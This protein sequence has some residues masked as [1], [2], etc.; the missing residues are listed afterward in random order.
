MFIQ[1]Y[2]K[3]LMCDKVYYEP[4][5]IGCTTPSLSC[6]DCRKYFRRIKGLEN[7]AP[8]T[9]DYKFIRLLLDRD[10]CEYCGRK[11]SW[12]EREIEHKTP[13]S[14]G[15]NNCNSNLC[16]SCHQCNVEKSDRTYEEYLDYRKT[17]DITSSEI[18]SKLDELSKHGLFKIEE[19]IVDEI[20]QRGFE[21]TNIKHKVIRDENGKVAGLRKVFIKPCYKVKIKW[22]VTTKRLTEW[23]IAYNE[24]CKKY[25]KRVL[26]ESIHSK[27]IEI[28]KDA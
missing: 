16:I 23:G 21:E 19:K 13:T 5:K 25:G 27:V 7:R 11:L 3:C 24:L 1:F 26:Y 10:T 18:K 9:I 15:G 4:E 2:N 12:E 28:T 17:L 22:H 8:G 20:E 14:K 6:P